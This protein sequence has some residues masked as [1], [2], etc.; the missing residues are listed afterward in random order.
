MALRFIPFHSLRPLGLAER[1]CLVR[2]P[3]PLPY[4]FSEAIF[5]QNLKL[6]LHF[7][8]I[9]AIHHSHEIHDLLKLASG[10]AQRFQDLLTFPSICKAGSDVIQQAE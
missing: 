1:V 6:S 5:S 4:S 3:C 9:Q 2:G 7:Q 8:G 10:F